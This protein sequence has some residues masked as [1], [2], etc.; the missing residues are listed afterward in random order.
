MSADNIIFDF[1][2]MA[3]KHV[4][5][6][7]NIQVY[8]TWGLSYEE[9]FDIKNEAD[10]RHIVKEFIIKQEDPELVF[11]FGVC[12]NPKCVEECDPNKDYNSKTCVHRLAGFNYNEDY[13]YIECYS[14][15]SYSIKIVL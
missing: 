13:T 11:E 9:T 15:Y 8:N 4:R 10:V 2:K 5:R 3:I 14:G 6:Y 7:V 1:N 12:K